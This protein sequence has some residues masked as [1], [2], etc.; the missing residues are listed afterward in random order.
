M[1]DNSPRELLGFVAVDNLTMSFSCIFTSYSSYGL[2]L[3]RNMSKRSIKV[4]LLEE[5][6]FLQIRV[7]ELTFSLSGIWI[8]CRLTRRLEPQTT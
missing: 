6:R 8:K 5:V 4:V 7:G 2:G 3:S 1:L